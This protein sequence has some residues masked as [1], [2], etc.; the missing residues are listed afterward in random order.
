MSEQL[1]D[2]HLL[3][4]NLLQHKQIYNEI[5]NRNSTTINPTST[6]SSASTILINNSVKSNLKTTSKTTTT[7]TTTPMTKHNNNN[8][9]I[10]DN[11]LLKGKFTKKTKFSATNLT[12]TNR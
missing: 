9:S 3:I 6:P 10:K 11:N 12:I 2:A 5:L 7:T 8:K 1:N 4:K